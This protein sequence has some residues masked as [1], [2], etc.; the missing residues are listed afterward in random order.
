MGFRVAPQEPP[1]DQADD[2]LQAVDIPTE[3]LVEVD[4][5]LMLA[6]DQAPTKGR[7]HETRPT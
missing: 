2:P 3:T 7:T 6:V 1:D 5:R 4:G